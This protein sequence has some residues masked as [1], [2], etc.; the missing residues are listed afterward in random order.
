MKF[1]VSSSALLKQLHSINGVVTNNPVVPILENFLF[2]IEPGKLTITASDLETSMITEL[3]IEA[4]EAG[5]I[6]APARILLDTLKNLPDQPV[7][8]TLDE[9]TYTI[10]ISSANGRYKLAGENAADFPRV[11]VW[12]NDRVVLVGDAAHAVSP[13]SGQGASMALEDAVVLAKCLRDVE[14][15]PE[16]WSTYESL[17]RQRVE[18]IVA[19]GRR[20]SSTKVAGPIGRRLMDALMPMVLR[21]VGRDG[22]G[23]QAWIY[24]YD[25][26]WDKPVAVG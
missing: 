21:R 16:A 12:R 10:E 20:T 17:R 1:I 3:P 7:T 23:G 26:D 14:S 9:E 13:S 2:E 19:A 24:D 22:A 18:K 15:V 4:H 11:P 25:L 5:R 6:A 8:F